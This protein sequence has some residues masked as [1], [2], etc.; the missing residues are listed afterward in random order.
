MN[1]ANPV[2]R[3]HE[4]DLQGLRDLLIAKH[5]HL[6]GEVLKEL[7]KYVRPDAREDAR[8]AGNRGLVKA[9]DSYEPTRR[10]SFV[11]FAWKCIRNEMRGERTASDWLEPHVRDDLRFVQAVHDR[12]AFEELGGPHHREPLE[13]RIAEALMNAQRAQPSSRKATRWTAKIV[14]ELLSVCPL[15]N[16]ISLDESQPDSSGEGGAE[17]LS[18]TIPDPSQAVDEQVELRE[19]VREALARLPERQ[20]DAARLR[21]IAQMGRADIAA[22]L[23]VPRATVDRLLDD[24]D[25]GLRQSLANFLESGTEAS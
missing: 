15:L 11:T 10:A 23:R 1:A 17:P 6:V 3:D 16:P 12:L 7:A 18:A 21:Y 5:E 9:A 13:Q 19:A 20:A 4:G 2:A 8:G 14:G 22:H 25:A 24:A